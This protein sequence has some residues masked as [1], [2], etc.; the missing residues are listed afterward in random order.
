MS[1]VLKRLPQIFKDSITNVTRNMI[2]TTI[3]A[4]KSR[5]GAT[6][7]CNDVKVSLSDTMKLHLRTRRAIYIVTQGKRG[8]ERILSTD[9]KAS[10][11]GW[12]KL[13]RRRDRASSTSRGHR[14]KLTLSPASQPRCASPHA[15]SHLPLSVPARALVVAQRHAQLRQAKMRAH[16]QRRKEVYRNVRNAFALASH[17]AAAPTK[18]VEPAALEVEP[19][20]DVQPAPLVYAARPHSPTT[21]TMSWFC[22]NLTQARPAQPEPEPEPE[23]PLPPLPPVAVPPVAPMPPSRRAAPAQP[24]RP[25][26]Q[27]KPVFWGCRAGSAGGVRCTTPAPTTTVTWATTTPRGPRRMCAPGTRDRILPLTPLPLTPIKARRF[28][29]ALS[30]GSQ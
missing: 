13:L 23:P 6:L 19:M 18:V 11:H 25:E 20:E 9:S 30:K 10:R 29:G 1:F 28:G 4:L 21:P 3:S 7:L 15:S 24:V 27:A 5:R 17:K 16:M 22:R 2:P 8:P 12:E 14:T 26:R